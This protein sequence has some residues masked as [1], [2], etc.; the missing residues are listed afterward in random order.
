MPSAQSFLFDEDAARRFE[1]SQMQREYVKQKVALGQ[2][3]EEFERSALKNL[4]TSH[5]R[6]A[7]PGGEALR[8]PPGLERII[9]RN[10]LIPVKYL[11]RGIE[12]A[13]SVGRVR[14]NNR[15]IGTGFLVTPTLLLT[16]AHVISSQ[17]EV[18]D[19]SVEFDFEE[20]ESGNMKPSVLFDLNPKGLFI[21]SPQRE[22][23]YTLVSVKAKSRDGKTS[24]SRYDFIQ[25]DS[26]TGKVLRGESV[27]VIQ[28]PNGEPKQIALRNS[29]LTA[30]LDRHLH[31]EADT[32]PGSSGS[33]VFNDQ[34]QVVC[35]HHSGVPRR[36]GE[37]RILT[38]SGQIWDEEDES[39]LDWI[40]NEGIRISRIVGDV[41]NQANAR[42]LTTLL[43]D[44]PE[45]STDNPTTDEEMIDMANEPS[46]TG[47][48]SAD[49]KSAISLS[50]SSDRSGAVRLT[51]P[52]HITVELGLPCGQSPS[53]GKI[54][55]H[56]EVPPE[57][58]KYVDANNDGS[59]EDEDIE[60]LAARGRKLFQEAQARKYYDE[61][62]D[63]ND[64]ATYYGTL[65]PSTQNFVKKLRTLVTDSH[66]NKLPYNK[67][68]VEFLYAWVDLRRNKKVRSVY[69]NIEFSAIN[70]IDDDLV[71]ERRRL[72]R[73]ESM[74]KFES[75]DE[76]AAERFR[77]LLEASDPFNC[78]HVVPQSWFSKKEPMRGDLH[79]LFSCES[80]C[81][82]FRSNHP[83][84]DFGKFPIG[85]EGVTRPKCG[86]LEGD[87]FEPFRA[88]AKVA[89]AT[90]YFA[91]RYPGKFNITGQAYD[92]AGL[93]KLIE[94]NDAV[95]PDEHERHRNQ[96][97]FEIQGNRNPFIDHPDWARKCFE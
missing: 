28:H 36:D 40:G 85:A 52:L 31:Y 63:A 7:I 78:E 83:Y 89:R 59:G 58:K 14:F 47:T 76:G 21:S 34:W 29:L 68:R 55:S 6:A 92:D 49:L 48:T 57:P 91:L 11:P 71:I 10:D 37:G 13:R 3:P 87:E 25:L 56:G 53:H 74:R 64:I 4:R 77:D 27:N 15:A 38:R 30:F 62:K 24:L 17:D 96:A 20:D 22:L 41:W 73:L 72:E 75:F 94:W 81:N 1:Q 95:A 79:H 18:N 16:N 44:F 45:P 23:D 46:D 66:T 80:N 5:M 43:T 42:G 26:R 9:G 51:I 8:E 97:I 39:Q 60:V 65:S 82:S 12:V 90:L 70:F 86:F 61:S 69:S 33:P 19:A 88:K 54:Q 93:E 67:A 32:Q 35:L 84:A 50:T 2:R